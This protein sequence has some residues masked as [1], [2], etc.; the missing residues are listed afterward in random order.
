MTQKEIPPFYCSKTLLS[1][2]PAPDLNRIILN[3]PHGFRF[4]LYEIGEERD[5]TAADRCNQLAAQLS[6]IWKKR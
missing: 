2:H 3:G 1:Y 5:H 6:E 4:T